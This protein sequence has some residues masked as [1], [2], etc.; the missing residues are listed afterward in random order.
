MVVIDLD[1][2]GPTGC[3]YASKEGAN[4]LSRSIENLNA[5][6]ISA[7]SFSS[8]HKMSSCAVP[9]LRPRMLSDQGMGADE[10]WPPD[11]VVDI[12]LL[13][14]GVAWALAIEASST[15]LV[16]AIWHLCRVL[17]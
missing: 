13:G 14:R 5:G 4:L 15:A 3:R 17:L 9:A 2:S 6:K 8:A 7:P 10:D 16:C 11:A 12:R 1:S